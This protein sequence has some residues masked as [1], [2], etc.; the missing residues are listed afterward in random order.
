[1]VCPLY[2]GLELSWHVRVVSAQVYTIVKNRKIYHYERV[3]AFLEHIHTLLPTLV[4]AIKHMKI[5]FAL[6]LSQKTA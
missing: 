4:P 6:L 3:L 2:A 5:V 1:S